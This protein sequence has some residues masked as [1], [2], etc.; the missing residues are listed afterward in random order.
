MLSGR[1]GSRF[2]LVTGTSG[3]GLEI[4]FIMCVILALRGG[5]SK[6]I[7]RDKEDN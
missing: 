3:S 7:D 4:I 2:C 1:G 6:L 5:D